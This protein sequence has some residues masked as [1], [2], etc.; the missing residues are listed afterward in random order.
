MKTCMLPFV[1]AIPRHWKSFLFISPSS[2]TLL[3]LKEPAKTLFLFKNLWINNISV[4]PLF[5]RH[6]F[7]PFFGTLILFC[8]EV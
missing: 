8:L 7:G 4:S 1:R 2:V 5:L 6:I 3:I